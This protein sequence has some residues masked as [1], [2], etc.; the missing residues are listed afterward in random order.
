MLDELDRIEQILMPIDGLLGLRNK[1]NMNLKAVDPAYVVCETNGHKS[2]NF[3][4]PDTRNRRYFD[5]FLE[6]IYGSK[7]PPTEDRVF[8]VDWFSGNIPH[9]I[10]T[11]EMTG[12]DLSA[13]I[14]VLE[15]GCYEGMSTCW[16]SDNMLRHLDSRMDAVDTFRGSV[17]HEGQDN[18]RL[19]KMFAHNLSLTKNPEKVTSHIG[20]SRAIM[21]IFLKEGRKYDVIYVDGG[22]M[23]EN[24]IV[25]GLCAYHLLKDDG[26]IIF[27]DYEWT[28]YD[29]RTVKEGLDRLEQMVPIKP[30][31]T[32]WQRSYVKS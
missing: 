25:D 21:P 12:K 19:Y 2:F 29:R 28:F 30:I 22:H 18:D 10:E 32:G 23:A 11:F 20:D 8:T 7:L 31:L 27:D 3:D 1:F 16:I 14:S 4:R 15:I 13:P 26:V 6:G 9:W 5:R 17:E 24:V